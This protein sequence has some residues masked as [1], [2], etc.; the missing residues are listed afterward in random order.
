MYPLLVFSILSLG[1]MVE[2][3]LFYRRL[4]PKLHPWFEALAGLNQVEEFGVHLKKLK[5]HPLRTI[6]EALLKHRDLDRKDLESMAIEES[7][8]QLQF[9]ESNLKGL[10]TLAL[11]SPLTGLLGTVLGIMKAFHETSSIGQVDAALLAGGI[12]EAMITTFVG[13]AIAIPTWAAYYYFSSRVERQT[14][15]MEYFSSRFIRLLHHKGWI[16]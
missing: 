8:E 13:L 2:R 10:S 6:L 11:L 1:L 5:K 15:F 9:L 12:W 14:F 3:F 7:E 4:S 16:A